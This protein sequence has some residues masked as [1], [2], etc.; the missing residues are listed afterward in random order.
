MRRQADLSSIHGF[1]HRQSLT[2]L[3]YDNIRRGS[4]APDIVFAGSRPVFDRLI[5]SCLC[6]TSK[7][8]E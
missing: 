5:L 6:Q 2:T 7:Q 4:H 1:H 3:P 8:S